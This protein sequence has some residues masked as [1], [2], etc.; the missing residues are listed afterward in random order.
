MNKLSSIAIAV[1]I[2]FLSGCNTVQYAPSDITSIVK[3]SGK[4]KTEIY[5]KARQWF[6]QTFVSGKSVV[7]YEDKEA[8]TIIGN[9]VADIGQGDLGFSNYAID[10]NIRIDA[11]DGRMRVI[12]KIISFTRTSVYDG[13]SNRADYVADE[14]LLQANAYVDNIVKSLE[15][16]I[17]SDKF[18]DDF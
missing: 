18:A 11:K 7:D 13:K 2:M 10:Y 8:G 3:I 4:T 16:Y 12:T 6:S 9:S 15:N 1:S 5:S 14:Q 17:K